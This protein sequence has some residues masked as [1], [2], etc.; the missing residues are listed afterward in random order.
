MFHTM[1]RASNLLP[2]GMVRPKYQFD[3]TTSIVDETWRYYLN[4]ETVVKG[5]YPTQKDKN[6]GSY[7]VR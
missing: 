2:G 7:M 3:L 4:I 6:T 1:P 5:I